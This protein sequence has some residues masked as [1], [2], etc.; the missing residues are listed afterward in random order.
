MLIVERQ[1]DKL[2]IA[3]KNALRWYKEYVFGFLV[4]LTLVQ[5]IKLFVGSPRPH[6]F[7]TCSPKEAQT[8]EG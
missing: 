2:E 3:K 6:F 5:C 4:N 8:C 7:D 1:Q